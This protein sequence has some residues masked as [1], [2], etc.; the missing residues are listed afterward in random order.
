M[1]A[2]MHIHLD[3]IG[4]IAGDMFV[5]ALLDAFPDRTDGVLH[6]VRLAELAGD[7]VTRLLDHDDGVL[8]G[9]RFDVHKS[10]QSNLQQV[11]HAHRHEHGHG[12]RGHSHH[13]PAHDHV[14]PHDHR[15][16]HQHGH[17]NHHGHDHHDHGHHHHNHTHWAQ[18]RAELQG[19]PLANGIKRHAIGIFSEL[20]WAEAEVHGKSVDDVTF[21]E[22]GNWDSIADIVAAATLIESLGAPS[23]SIGFLPMGRG[24][25]KTAHGELP[26]PAPATALLL[27]GFALHDDGRSGER[28][29]PTGA[30]I[31]R[32]LRPTQGI[33]TVPKTLRT[34]G[35]GFG[36]R[37]LPG[38]SNVL[39]VLAFERSASTE[40][41]SVGII[42]FEI[43]DQ[44][45]E[46]L[47]VALDHLRATPG[48]IDATQGLTTGKKG[49]VMASIQV[50]ARPEKMD[51]AISACFRQ[52]TTL[53]VRT[54]VETR[55]I[56]TRREVEAG[57]LRVKIADRPGGPTA[58]AESD[59][60]ASDATGHRARSAER[61]QA[62]YVALKGT[63]HDH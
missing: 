31:L 60:V 6:A 27:E 39:R 15:H 40:T 52:T 22:V 11:S 2:A 37:K 62:E 21:H 46:E 54:R 56:L 20:A 32:Y 38:M 7:V 34:T 55:T 23:W 57:G 9:K 25:V 14:H 18:L 3:A 63:K 41:D 28:V 44:T 50:L 51:D 42:Q 45:G 5:A 26:V 12:T 16:D 35:H 10:S 19:S 1:D 29:T 8:V 24:R 17:D 53:G 47:A 49:R 61:Q 13:S 58:K 59:D 43:D 33:G 30:A 36:T 4:G 48:V